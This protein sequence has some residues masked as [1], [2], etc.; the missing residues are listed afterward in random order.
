M[1]FQLTEF[2][3][4][5][6][7][8]NAVPTDSTS[9]HPMTQNAVPTD[10]ISYHPM[11]QNAVPTDSTSYHTVTQNDVPTD[12][13]SYCSSCDTGRLQSILAVHVSLATETG[14]DCNPS[15]Y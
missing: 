15:T 11:T 4:T 14:T 2:P 7:T 5:A 1:P 8:E 9:Y 3:I 10:S 13:I 6:V 12:S